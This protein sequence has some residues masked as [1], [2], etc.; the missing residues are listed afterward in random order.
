M[1]IVNPTAKMGEDLA[2]QYLKSLG[3]KIIERNYKKRFEEIDIVAVY[4]NILIF[5][6][7]KTRTSHLFGTPLEAITPWKLKSLI[8]GALYYK[9]VH[10][11]LPESMR[12]DAISI[13]MSETGK[14]PSIEH[15]K[16]ITPF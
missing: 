2:C 11:N 9:L 14:V 1:R 12:I 4:D 15:I 5:I 8:K 10:K 13:D 16:N 6:E 3:Y 7:V